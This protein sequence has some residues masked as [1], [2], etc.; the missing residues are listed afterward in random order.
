MR[1]LLI[2]DKGIPDIIHVI[3][4]LKNGIR[5]KIFL[6]SL[7]NEKFNPNRFSRYVN[8]YYWIDTS[9]G[10]VTDKLIDL[11]NRL[12]IDVVLP[13]KLSTIDLFARNRGVIQSNFVIPPHP[14]LETLNV[15]GNKWWLHEWLVSKGFPSPDTV[16]AQDAK[17][18]E[19]KF[20]CLLKPAE[21]IGGKG[22]YLINNYKESSDILSRLKDR[23]LSYVFQQ[24]IEGEDIDIS[25]LAQEGKIMAY[26]IQKGI[27]KRKF[28]WSHGIRFLKSD[29]LLAMTQKIIHS[30]NWSGIA[31][32]DFRYSNEHDTYY[33]VDFNVRYWSSLPGSM[34]AGVNFP[35]TACLI[36]LAKP[37]QNTRYREQSFY[38]TKAALK[39][40]IGWITGKNRMI[41]LR[42]TTLPELLKDPLPELI[43]AVK[44]IFKR[45]TGEL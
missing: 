24:L 22:I 25:L 20:P 15:V 41:N 10:K 16:L 26:T 39:M 43:K 35:E 7:Q 4:S 21:G 31:H 42:Q 1:I 27:L 28:A 38:M 8:G 45:N 14:E 30:L 32:L 23:K 5:K 19:I 44:S 17:I 40:V 11:T 29:K 33:L 37:P 34:S 2:D 3:R 13:A 6:V 12:H 18:N 36:A 9:E